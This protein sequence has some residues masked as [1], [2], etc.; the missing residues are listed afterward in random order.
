MWQPHLVS[1]R[2]N[3]QF[4]ES[5]Y[6]LIWNQE[7]ELSTCLSLTSMFYT[8]FKTTSSLQCTPV[9]TYMYM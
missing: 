3:T 9:H 2:I 5:I 8:K 1:E 4:S 6:K 7:Y